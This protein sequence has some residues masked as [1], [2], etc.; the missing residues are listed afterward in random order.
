[1]VA[2]TPKP[3]AVELAGSLQPDD[4]SAFEHMFDSASDLV[5]FGS[6]AAEVATM[7]SDWDLFFVGTE[8][9]PRTDRLDIVWK[10]PIEV[11]EAKWLGSELAS[12]IAEYGVRL[13]GDTGWMAAVALGE[14]AIRKKHR[15]LVVRVEGLWEYWD[16]IHPEFK[17][18]HLKTIRR[19]VQ[20]LHLLME[21]IAVPPTPL[22][23]RIWLEDSAAVG[24]WLTFIKTLELGSMQTRQRLFRAADLITGAPDHTTPVRIGE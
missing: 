5:L 10:T 23:D 11:G 8:K 22:L 4:R 9:P 13:K 17:R 14:T 1:M 12:H 19:K 6:R 2:S 7:E 20:R 18:K 15:R 21:G 16:R 24:R 3:N